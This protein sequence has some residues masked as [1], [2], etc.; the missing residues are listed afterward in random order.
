MNCDT[1]QKLWRFA[2]LSIMTKQQ[3]TSQ[4]FI[5]CYEHLQVKCLQAFDN[6]LSGGLFILKQSGSIALQGQIQP[7]GFRLPSPVLYCRCFHIY[8]PCWIVRCT[9]VCMKMYMLE[10]RFYTSAGVQCLFFL[11]PQSTIKEELSLCVDTR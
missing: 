1:R 2:S 4:S 11:P 7:T 8:V 3:H 5:I 6:S 9:C 10:C